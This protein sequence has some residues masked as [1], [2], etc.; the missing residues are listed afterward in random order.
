[1]TDE[2]APLPHNKTIYR[3]RRN[4]YIIVY[5]QYFPWSQFTAISLYPVNREFET[6]HIDIINFFK[7]SSIGRFVQMTKNEWE[8]HEQK[9]VQAQRVCPAMTFLVFFCWFWV[10]HHFCDKQGSKPFF[11]SYLLVVQTF[12]Q[13]E[14]LKSVLLLNGNLKIY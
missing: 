2:R 12:G 9:N 6:K 10:P 4:I 13:M 3:Y 7:Q 8:V 5:T 1:M 11:L 14:C